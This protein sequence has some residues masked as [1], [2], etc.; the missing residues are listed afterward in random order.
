MEGFRKEEGYKKKVPS[1]S[2]SSDTGSDSEVK[3]S[4]ADMKEIMVMFSRSFRKGKF[5]HERDSA[6]TSSTK[7]K[8]RKET[9][10]EVYFFK[11]D[12]AKIKC[13]NC[14]ELGHFSSECKKPMNLG[15]GKALM[16]TQKDWD[17][18][19]SSEDEID[20]DNIALMDNIFR[21]SRIS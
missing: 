13:F 8:I 18:S 9:E 11:L 12:K 19:R 17:D 7:M 3:G 1:E 14:S 4:E 20:Y 21:E 10:E 5:T 6:K 16:T 2:E 15:K